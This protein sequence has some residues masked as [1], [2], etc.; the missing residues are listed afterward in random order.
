MRF[1]TLIFRTRIFLFESNRIQSKLIRWFTQS[2][3]NPSNLLS[4]KNFTLFFTNVFLKHQSNW[5]CWSVNKE[6]YILP[7]LFETSLNPRDACVHPPTLNNTRRSGLVSFSCK[8]R[9]YMPFELAVHP[10]KSSS[11]YGA[12]VKL[13]ST[14]AKAKFICVHKNGSTSS[15]V[16]RLILS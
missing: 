1:S 10:F 7:A 13:S 12:M 15:G 5:I 8:I 4:R 3:S 2:R 9:S 16:K 11:S 14:L 6:T